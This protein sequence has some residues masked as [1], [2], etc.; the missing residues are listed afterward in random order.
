MILVAAPMGSAPIDFDLTGERREENSLINDIRARVELWRG[1]NY[2]GVT[3]I[4]RKLLQHW[5]GTVGNR[6]DR[7]LWCR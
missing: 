7:I 2:P 3:P 6:E 1:R 5:A 4:S